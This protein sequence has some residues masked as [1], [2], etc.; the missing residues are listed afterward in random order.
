MT[1]A[2]LWIVGITTL[3]MLSPGPDMILVMRNTLAGNRRAGLSTSLG[4]LTGNFVHIGYCMLGLGWLIANSIAA[5]G[6]LKLA[7]AAYLVYLG[8]SSIRSAGSDTPDEARVPGQT[9]RN[10]YVQG[11]LNNLLN[12]KGALFYLGVFT[13]VI[14]P[15]TPLLRSAVLVAAMVA[16]S[17]LFWVV[18]VCGLQLPP[19]RSLLRR[20]RRTVDRVFGALLIALGLRVALRD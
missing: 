11:L 2:L 14:H 9:D 19:V 6:V 12:P 1:E 8:W 4:V 7:G 5:Y 13:Q 15:D 18:F 17:A 3:C 20:S 16:T 10:A